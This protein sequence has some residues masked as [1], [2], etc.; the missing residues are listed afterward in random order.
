M[1]N[2]KVKGSFLTDE[3]MAKHTSYGIGGPAQAYITPS[4]QKDLKQILILSLIHI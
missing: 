4:D 3:P 2:K 1:L